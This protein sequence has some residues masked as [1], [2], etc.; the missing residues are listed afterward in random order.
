MRNNL[1]ICAVPPP[2]FGYRQHEL[3]QD[4]AVSVGATYFSEKTGDD[5]SII[6]FEDLG[7]AQRVVVSRDETVIVKGKANNVEQVDARVGELRDAHKIATR[8]GDKD[9]ILSRIA[10]LTGGIGTIKVEE[11]PT[12]SRRSSS[13]ALTTRCALYGPPFKRVSFQGAG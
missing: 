2:N 6:T 3:M 9:F 7:H 4:I 10:S 8:K 12:W 5:L 1:K 11:T 13:T